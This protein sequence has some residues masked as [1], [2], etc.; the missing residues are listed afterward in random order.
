M[1][2]IN[3][4]TVLTPGGEAKS[5][6]LDKLNRNRILIGRGAYHGS[7]SSQLRNDISID[8]E[9]VSRAHCFLERDSKGN[10]YIEDEGSLNGLVFQNV[11]IDTPHRLMDGD[12][13]YIWNEGQKDPVVLMF[14]SRNVITGEM[15]D[16][17]EDALHGIKSYSLRSGTRWV[18]GRSPDCDIVISHPTISR[19]HC[20]IT[21]ENG[22]YYIADN[23]STNGVILNSNPLVG[24]EA[25]RQMDRISIAGFSF[26][27]SDDCLYVYEITGGVSVC[28]EHLSRYVGKGKKTKLILDDINLFIEPNQFVAIIGGSGAGKTTLMNAL[29]GMTDF[30]YGQV[31][32]NGES[33]RSCGKSLRSLMGYVPQQDIVYDTLT[34]ERML[35][36]SAKIRMP[37]DSSKEDIENKITE[38]L[39]MVELSAHRNTIISKLSG[40]ERKRA[41]IAVE[42]LASPKL[43]FLDE[44]SSGLDPGTE[45][46]L[47]QMLKRLADSGKTVIMITHTVQNIDLCDQVVCM[48]RGGRLCFSGSPEKTLQFFGKKSMTDVY[49]ILNDYSEE[50]AEK[51]KDILELPSSDYAGEPLEKAS[52]SGKSFRTSWKDFAT[53]TSR[54]MEILKSDHLRLCLLLFM[55]IILTPLVCIAMQSDGNFYNSNFYNQISKLLGGAF[56]C[57]SFPYVTF[58]D[59]TKLLLTFSCAGFWTGIFNSIQEIS[60][61]RR[62]YERERFAGVGAVP[63]VFSKFIPLLLL[64][65]VQAVFMF[66][67]FQFMTTTTATLNGDVNSSYTKGLLSMSINGLGI[68]PLKCVGENFMTTFMGILCAMCIGLAVSSIASNELALVLCPICLMPQILFSDVV[69][70]L[71]GFTETLSQ[72]ITCRWSTLAYIIS[73]KNYNTLYDS[74]EFSKSEWLLGEVTIDNRYSGTVSGAWLTMLAIS[75]VCIVLSILILHYRRR[76]TR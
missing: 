13:I 49:D 30:T 76:Q 62:I 59:T 32:I 55:P 25:L 41:S 68:D 57:T 40:G 27:F 42:L 43:F 31:L 35:Y 52:S 1:S 29:S 37:I 46:H 20:V 74:C 11:K 16:S 14:S 73:A 64:C 66:S 21:Y 48:G 53:M 39:E 26:I 70:K 19:K 47:M 4:I 44:P 7:P 23:N 71:S 3:S 63:Y 6:D 58:S 69:S 67:I 54:Y 51:Y 34:L 33:I 8:V 60:K 45:K 17:G 10:W 5:Y 61:E 22:T 28:A 38:T 9:T 56:D 75:V 15:P 12:K 72:I 36:Y 18:I 24:K 50:A 2:I 65:L